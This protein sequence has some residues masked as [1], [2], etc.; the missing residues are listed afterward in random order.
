M[1]DV[2]V[3]SNPWNNSHGISA[4]MDVNSAKYWENRVNIYPQIRIAV[5]NSKKPE[6]HSCWSTS[7]C[8]DSL[9]HHQTSDC[10][11]KWKTLKC[12]QFLTEVDVLN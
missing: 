1:V 5:K 6:I 11:L 9:L 4:K 10:L 7:L 8:R 12:Q 2:R 3:T